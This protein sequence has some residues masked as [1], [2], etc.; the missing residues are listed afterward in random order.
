MNTTL[1]II[2]FAD[3]VC[4]LNAN[5]ADSKLA[6]I[7]PK[8][9]LVGQIGLPLTAKPLAPRTNLYA[10][11]AIF[12]T[13]GYAKLANASRVGTFSRTQTAR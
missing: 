2:A 13:E 8:F 5:L 9:G 7:E 4:G 1:T 12:T 11:E 3:D 6:W 10:H